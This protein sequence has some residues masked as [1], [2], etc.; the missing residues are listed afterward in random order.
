MPVTTVAINGTNV[1]LLGLSPGNLGGWLNGP[2]FE[3][4]TSPV[5]GRYGLSVTG[6]NVAAAPRDITFSAYLAGSTL[7]DRRAKLTALA[8]T[9]TGRL[10]IT[11]ADETTRS[12]FGYLARMPVR[13]IGPGLLAEQPVAVVDVVIRCFDPVWYAT[14]ATTMSTAVPSTPL[15]FSTDGSA[16]YRRTQLTLNGAMSGEVTITLKTGGGATTAL[17][18]LTGTLTGSEYV[19]I[20]LDPDVATVTRWSAGVGTDVISWLNSADGIG[21]FVVDPMDSPTVEFSGTA[22]SLA[23]SYRVSHWV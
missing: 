10:E 6:A 19:V 3:H 5:V 14:T 20:D 4:L 11:V 17:L 7:A 15:S 13:T 8:K 22:A 21:A 1:E 2:A 16:P 9:L 12:I 18:R 23:V